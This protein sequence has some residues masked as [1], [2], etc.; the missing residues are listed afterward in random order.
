M[1]KDEI[2]LHVQHVKTLN[3]EYSRKSNVAKCSTTAA[4]VAE[5]LELLATR[6]GK[7]EMAVSFARAELDTVQKIL[8]THG[9]FFSSHTEMLQM[10]AHE[11][12]I[13]RSC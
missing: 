1:W 13:K 2:V 6:I 12:E 3:E 7:T 5:E 4:G 10:K 11:T 8:L 9:H